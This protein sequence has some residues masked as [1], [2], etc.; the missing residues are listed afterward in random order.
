MLPDPFY[1]LQ[2]GLVAFVSGAV[3]SILVW[4]LLGRPIVRHEVAKWWDGLVE[5]MGDPKDEEMDGMISLFA[6]RGVRS[7]RMMLKDP[8]FNKEFNEWMNGYMTGISKQI[9]NRLPG[10]FVKAA[11]EIKRALMGGGE[12]GKEGEIDPMQM[13]MGMIGGGGNFQM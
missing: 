11:P 9:E 4:I 5:R 1:M 10:I 8:G 2:V 6:A 7:F 13:I 3:G 12:G